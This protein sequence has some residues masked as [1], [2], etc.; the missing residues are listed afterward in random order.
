MTD[1]DRK[2]IELAAHSIGR[3]VTGWSRQGGVD[4]AILDDETYWQP[5]YKNAITDCA[6]DALR[7]AARLGLEVEINH[8]C[9]GGPSDPLVSVRGYIYRRL[10]ADEWAEDNGEPLDMATCRAIV[11]AAAEIGRILL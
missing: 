6:G 10:L 11:R 4:V 5:L 1:A 9:P 7:L 3:T 8:K 2:L